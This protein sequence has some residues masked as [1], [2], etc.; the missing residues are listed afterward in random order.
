MVPTVSI[1]M[2]VYNGERWLAQALESALAQTFTDFEVVV[3]DDGSIDGSASIVESFAERDPRVR[4]VRTD[5][6]GVRSARRVS[7]AEA[8]GRFVAF[9]DA[10]DEWLPIKL[11][12]QLPH[13]DERTV[14]FADMYLMHGGRRTERRWSEWLPVPR[15]RY[16]ATGLF[17]HLLARG[18]F[19]PGITVLVPRDL[20]VGAGAFCYGERHGVGS[21]EPAA[22]Y[23]MWLLLALRGVR[24]DYVDEPLAVSRRRADSV[25]ADELRVKLAG[26]AIFDGLMSETRGRDRRLLRRARRRARKRL[27]VAYRKRGWQQIVRGDI[28]AARRELARSLRH[29]PSSPRAWLAFFLT[30][31]PRLAQRIVQGRL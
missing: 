16:P 7:L 13:A 5:H 27:E 24:F 2:P 14:V 11:E 6:A 1:L 8:R 12:R 31:H 4:L 22:D 25:S 9:L 29:R 19:I 30:V 15:L 23:E 18:N 26:A 28:G 3:V 17:A 10:D 20:L 21:Y